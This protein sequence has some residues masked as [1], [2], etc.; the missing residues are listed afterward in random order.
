MKTIKRTIL[1]CT[2]ALLLAANVTAAPLDE[3][4]RTVETVIADCLAQLP[5]PSV[6]EYGKIMEELA[7]TGAEG[8]EI[9]ADML[10]PAAQGKNAP[11]EYAINGVASHVTK[12]GL[13]AQRKEVCKGLSAA[14]ARCTDDANR[15]FLLSQLQLCATADTADTIAGYFDDPYLSDPALRAL[16]SIAG[17]EAV[18]LKLAK[19]SDITQEQ[20]AALACALGEKEMAEAEQLLLGWLPEADETTRAAI[21]AA[22]GSCGSAASLKRLAAAARSAGFIDDKTAATDSYLRL[23]NRLV[24]QKASRE[25]IKAARKLLGCK[26]SNVRGAAL[27]ILLR[28]QGTEALPYVLKALQ[29]EDIQYRNAALR[30]VGELADDDVYA[31][32]AAEH[33]HL[34]DEAWADVIEWFGV[35]HAAS[36]IDAVT[37]A[38]A[39]PNDRLALAGIHAAGRLGGDKALAALIAALGGRHAE[40]AA[41]DTGHALRV[42]L[43]VLP[44]VVAVRSLAVHPGVGDLRRQGGE[45]LVIREIRI[46]GQLQLFLIIAG[47]PLQPLVQDH[48]HHGIVEHG[49]QRLFHLR[50][51]VRQ[52]DGPDLPAIGLGDVIGR[53]QDIP[54][55]EGRPGKDLKTVFHLRVLDAPAQGLPLLPGAKLGHLGLLKHGQGYVAGA[56]AGVVP[57]DLQV[58]GIRLREGDDP[59]HPHILHVC[60]VV[61]LRLPLCLPLLVAGVFLGDHIR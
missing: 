50:G 35:R 19:R 39:S 46:H 13:E 5:A 1:S 61:P 38:V 31:T 37:E 32:I 53:G 59:R 21:Y 7:A 40:P 14:L 8:I 33:S 25:A 54:L 9:L 60:G 41:Q 45:H 6:K 12:E 57:L 3:R 58:L 47:G 44:I 20:K 42:Q 28:A 17:S 55:A 18:L 52:G 2:L 24:D 27:Q 48:R 30:Y 15:A 26:V 49:A 43:A 56:V 16:T 36:Q 29:T 22:L 51:P 4:Q 11:V 34:S 10:V 23:L